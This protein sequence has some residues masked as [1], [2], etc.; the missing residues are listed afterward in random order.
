MAM[1][2]GYNT[3][4]LAHH[5]LF[6]AVSLLADLGYESVAITLD[7]GVLNPFDSR[8]DEQIERMRTLLAERKMRSVVE[9]GARFL[10]DPRVKHEPTLVSESAEA[11]ARRIDFLCRAVD[12]AQ[13]L[14]SDCVSLWSGVARDGRHQQ[15]TTEETQGGCGDGGMW[16]RLVGGLRQVVEYAVNRNVRIG[17]EPEPGMFIDSMGRYEEL[18]SRYDAPNFVL[19]LDIGH[20]HCQGETPIADFIRRYA[21]RLVNVH[22][23]DMRRGIHE[24][25]MFGEGEIDF[26]P[27]LAVLAEVGYR[28]GVH[29][30][31]SRHSHEGPEAARRAIE[32]L[33]P[34]W[35]TV[36]DTPVGGTPRTK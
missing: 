11:R 2:I 25:L 22:L 20:L 9:T 8:L 4:G 3:N 36:D 32:F 33:L 12:I 28:G 14:G 6:D 26:P 19:T 21:D 17:F 29:V 31:L 15:E 10:L 13:R 27:V 30:E 23:E 34:M 24:H 7:H 18:L 16:E 1:R 5:D 35:P